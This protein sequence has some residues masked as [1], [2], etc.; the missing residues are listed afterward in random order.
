MGWCDLGWCECL[1]CPDV[2]FVDV[3][4]EESRLARGPVSLNQ[5]HLVDVPIVR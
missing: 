1:S 5:V 4:D 3:D 2:I